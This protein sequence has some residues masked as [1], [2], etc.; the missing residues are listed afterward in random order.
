MPARD[1]QM[2][3]GPCR[4]PPSEAPGQVA[5]EAADLETARLATLHGYDILESP[6]ELAFADAVDIAAEICC[7]PMALVSFVDKD[8]QWFAAERGVGLQETPIGQSVCAYAMHAGSIF[9]VDDLSQDARF[10]D[11]TLVTGAPYL[12]FYAGAPLRTEG[13][14]PLG[15]ICVLDTQSRPGGLNATQERAL[16][17]LG[18]QVMAQLEL[19]RLGRQQRELLASKDRLQV[20]TASHLAARN[21]A[22]AERDLLM[23]EV[24]HR[25]KNSLMMVQSL[26][27]LQ[28]RAA[29]DP[30]A[31]ELLRNSAAR[32]CTFGAMHEQ[33][34]QLGAETHVDLA[35]YVDTLLEN[36]RATQAGT[37]RERPIVLHA[38]HDL[39]PAADAANFGLI[40]VEL[41]TN[42][43]KY[44]AGAIDVS[45][46]RVGQDVLRLSVEDE[47]RGL[48]ADFDPTASRGFGM[49]LVTGLLKSQ[50]RG[51]LEVDRTRGHTCFVVMFRAVA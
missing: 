49:R 38:Q 21:A 12:R 39:W 43:L 1:T 41:V 8:R 24:N 50:Q 36:Q 20:E 30:D 22:L 4:I 13:G 9:T 11:N 47:G 17:A 29:A 44:G 19:R 32:V 14:E 25:V 45:L 35:A 15:T 48:P 27:N 28:A 40:L 16:M 5:R 3:D 26:L 31:A 23:Q 33:L 10:R 6:P 37:G 51:W 18:R 42:S 46:E 7:T 34:Y 2:M